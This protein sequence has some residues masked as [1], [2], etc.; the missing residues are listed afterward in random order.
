MLLRAAAIIA[1]EPIPRVLYATLSPA[2]VFR[3]S[4]WKTIVIQ[5]RV[6]ASLTVTY[7]VAREKPP[8]S[9]SLPLSPRVTRT[10]AERVRTVNR[11]VTEPG[12]LYGRRESVAVCHR[13]RIWDNVG[14]NSSGSS[15]AGNA[16]FSCLRAT[17]DNTPRCI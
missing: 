6:H 9:L 10:P 12:R 5:R 14:R 3:V 13:S 15:N 4:K 16:H 2:A 1:R 8:L 17:R 11:I 7:R